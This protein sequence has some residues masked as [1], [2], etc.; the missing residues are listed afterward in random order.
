MTTE[1]KTSKRK[2]I[3]SNSENTSSKKICSSDSKV[4]KPANEEAEISR[5]CEIK[6]FSTLRRG[7]GEET[8]S[9]P[10][11]IN[12][13]EFKIQIFPG[14][15]TNR[16]ENVSIFLHLCKPARAVIRFNLSIMKND[17]IYLTHPSKEPV[18]NNFS[19]DQDFAGFGWEN[20]VPYDVLKD[21]VLAFTGDSLILM[22][23]I[24]DLDVN[25]S[26]HRFQRLHTYEAYLNNEQFSDVRIIVKGRTIYAH[27]VILSGNPVFAAMFEH[28]TL[29][30]KENIIKIKDIDFKVMHELI[31]FI[32][33][34]RV[35]D[36]EPMAKKLLIAADMYGM[37][38][39]KTECGKCISRDLSISN[40][41]E[42]INFADCYNAHELKREAIAF[43]M[44]HRKDVVGTQDF[45][46]TLETVDIHL[47]ADIIRNLS[48]SDPNTV[49]WSP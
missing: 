41:L 19:V 24:Y 6:N 44:T 12:N 7:I 11:V 42:Y 35:R 14:G 33:V 49:L 40:V 8:N 48:Q 18:V 2:S 26:L 17:D 5:I 27:K 25:K 32:Y 13:Y 45:D 29:E 43:F 16:R 3:V 9:P 4:T 30:S 36:I 37:D 10:I 22:L 23:K 34:G 38:E 1:T 47:I 20:F 15:Y 39:L 46:R 21:N 31:R 28:D